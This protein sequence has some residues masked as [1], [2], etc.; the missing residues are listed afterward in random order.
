MDRLSGNARIPPRSPKGGRP[1]QEVAARLN[2]HILDA[3]LEQFITHGAEQTSMN[4]IA[5]AASV[6][7]R[8]LYARFES[9]IGLLMAA[10]EHGLEHQLDDFKTHIP[11]GSNREQL[12][13]LAGE[14]LDMSLEPRVIGLQS[15]IKWLEAQD[16]GYEKRIAPGDLVK[17]GRGPFINLLKA[18]PEF[19]GVKDEELDFLASFLLDALVSSPHR[20]ILER[21][22]LDNTAQ[23]KA[24]YQSKTLDLIVRD[25]HCFG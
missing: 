15:L 19:D 24:E 4:A 18:M 25:F 7:K 14:M 20:R 5:A 8:T 21:H 10:I 16:K 2:T 6:S 11:N 9:K 12:L 23:S 3:A 1:T 22:D 13:S 17:V